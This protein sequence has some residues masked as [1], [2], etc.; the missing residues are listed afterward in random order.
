LW[1]SVVTKSENQGKNGDIYAVSRKR[2]LE[3]ILS[4]KW[5]KK[6]NNSGAFKA[7]WMKEKSTRPQTSEGQT[8]PKLFSVSEIINKFKPYSL[9]TVYYT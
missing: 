1:K 5:E 3:T 8:Q 4:R 2:K 7:L 9:T 6:P